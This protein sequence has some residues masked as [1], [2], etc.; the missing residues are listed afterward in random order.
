MTRWHPNRLRLQ[1]L[2]AL[3][4][5]AVVQLALAVWLKAPAA[6]D[7]RPAGES[8]QRQLTIITNL[9]EAD[10]HLQAAFA[11]EKA[12]A[13]ESASDKRLTEWHQQTEQAH[14]FTLRAI[15]EL[16][17]SQQADF[18]TSWQA[19]WD[20]SREVIF[21]KQSGDTIVA[22]AQHK[23]ASQQFFN[24]L[25]AFID[26]RYQ[27]QLASARQITPPAPQP[28]RTP[29]PWLW[30]ALLWTAVVALALLLWLPQQQAQALAAL[31]QPLQPWLGPVDGSEALTQIEA[32]SRRC[33][34]LGGELER[35]SQVLQSTAALCQQTNSNTAAPDNNQPWLDEARQI[36]QQSETL[37]L[38][39]QQL[40]EA[41]Q[42]V[43]QLNEENQQ[44][45]TRVVASVRQLDGELQQTAGQVD[46]LQ[47]QAASANSVLDEIRSIADQ[48]NLLALNAAIEAARAGEQG[49]GFAVVADEVRSLATRTQVST[50]SI[51]TTLADLQKQVAAAVAA[52]ANHSRAI[53]QAAEQTEGASAGLDAINQQLCEIASGARQLQGA[54]GTQ[55]QQWQ[56]LQQQLT[57]A[58]AA[59]EEKQPW[60]TRLTEVEGALASTRAQIT[61]LAGAWRR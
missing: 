28:A 14:D 56:Q 53:G 10:R 60:Q 7:T 21:F 33:Q 40:A 49:R 27:Q 8:L 48:T 61:E 24:R 42:A 29:G 54:S 1:L 4:L 13:F 44:A 23:S 51:Q 3:G 2:L 37:S 30:S 9:L 45:V 12:I 43:Q 39:S 16:D 36:S 32:L 17:A 41:S 50:T 31:W 38:G 57:T 47:S 18:E 6:V 19:W 15:T 52:I 26:Q 25:H 20:T 58:V 55:A 59:S 35:A 11:T 22:V 5:I 46:E 34:A